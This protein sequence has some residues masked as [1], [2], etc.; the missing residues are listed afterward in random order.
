MSGRRWT[1]TEIRL[2]REIYPDVSAADLEQWTPVGGLVQPAGPSTA[3]QT[4]FGQEIITAAR[5]KTEDFK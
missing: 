4:N 5:Q 1:P 3:W 2:V